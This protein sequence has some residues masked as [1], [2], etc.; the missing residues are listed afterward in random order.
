MAA[1]HVKARN[2]VESSGSFEREDMSTPRC[3][4][5]VTP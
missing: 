1:K 3:N 4:R 5:E 2:R